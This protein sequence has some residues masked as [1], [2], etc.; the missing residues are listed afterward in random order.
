[1]LEMMKL[2]KEMEKEV[3]DEV[4]ESRSRRREKGKGKINVEE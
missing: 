2:R 4:I 3:M 1:M